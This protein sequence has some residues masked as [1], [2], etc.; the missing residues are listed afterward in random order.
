MAGGSGTVD[1][2]P[3]ITCRVVDRIF[4]SESEPVLTFDAARDGWARL[5]ESGLRQA[6]VL[7]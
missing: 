1:R 3:E 6:A 4:P 2:V 7:W 5:V